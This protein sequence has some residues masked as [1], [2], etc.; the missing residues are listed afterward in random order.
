ML[1]DRCEAQQVAVHSA[2]FSEPGV[3]CSN[4]VKTGRVVTLKAGQKALA[5]SCVASY[6]SYDLV[7]SLFCLFC[8]FFVKDVVITF[9]CISLICISFIH[10][11]CT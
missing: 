1:S 5:N 8:L 10:I 11:T 6:S 9:K 2:R 7:L 3:Q 4:K